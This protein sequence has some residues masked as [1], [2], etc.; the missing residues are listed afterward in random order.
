MMK[1]NEKQL[2]ARVYHK[3]DKDAF[4]ELYRIHA[5]KIMRFLQYRLPTNS[6]AE[7]ELNNIFMRAWTYCNTAQVESMGALLFKIARNRIADYY[8]AQKIS[9]VEMSEEIKATLADPNTSDVV[10]TNDSEVALIE[11]VLPKLHRPYQELIVMYYIEQVPVSEIAE[12]LDKTE[13]NVRVTISRAVQA[14]RELLEE[15]K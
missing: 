5:S 11:Q 8:K 9:Q 7:D 3:Q 13:N 10:M 2:L 15:T 6:D 1:P 12:M 14:L 4:A